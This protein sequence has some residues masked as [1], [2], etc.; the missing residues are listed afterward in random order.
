VGTKIDFAVDPNGADGC[1]ATRFTATI[2]PAP[3]SAMVVAD[4]AAEFS[5]TQGQDNWH[6]G[7]Y[8]KSADGNGVY[9]FATDFNTIDP[10]WTFGGA[11]S[12]GPGDPPWTTL[13]QIDIHPNGINNGPEQ[14]VIRRWVSEVT[15]AITID[16]HFAKSNPGGSGSSFHVF[17]NGVLR[18][19]VSLGGTDRTG[20]QRVLNLNVQTGDKIDFAQSP[21]GPSGETDDGADGSVFNAVIY[22]HAYNPN[23]DC[24]LVADSQADWSM[25]G[26]Q[27][28]LGWRYG[29]YDRTADA[30]PGYQP[31]DFT[32]FPS[33]FP[34]ALV[35]PGAT[36]FWTGN[37]W[38]WQPPPAPWDT[39]GRTDVHPTGPAPEHWVM[40]RWVSTV[41]GTVR[42]DWFTRKTNPFGSGVTGK[43][44]HNGIEKDSVTLAGGDTTGVS[45]MLTLSGVNVGD[46][47]ELA[48]TPLGVGGD[49]ADGADGSANGMT[50]YS[51]VAAGDCVITDVAS[52]MKNVNS[53]AY[54]RLPFNAP[55]PACIDQLKFRLKYDDGFVAYLNG[56]E[57]ARR[58]APSLQTAGHFADSVADWS[59]SG[60]QG[61]NNWFYGYYNQTADGDG[62]YNATTDFNPTDPN[63]TF[64]GAWTLGPGD[65]PW[66][67]IGQYD[68]HPN[69]INNGHN[70]WVIRRWVSQLAGTA[71]VTLRFAKAS[72]ACGNG[73]TGRLH[74]NGSLIY[75]NT[76]A[77]DDSVGVNVQLPVTVAVGDKLDFSLDALGT[78]GDTNDGCDGSTA[79]MHVRR[80][81]LPALAWNSRATAA[82]TATQALVTEVIDISA[83]R[84]ALRQGGN[85]LAIHGLNRAI[86]DPDFL[87]APELTA[88]VLPPTILVQPGSRTNIL[89]DTA[90]FAV[91]VLTCAPASYQWHSNGV[92]MPGETASTLLVPALIENQAGY[93][94]T[95]STVAGSVTS[96][97]ATLTVNRRPVAGDNGASTAM[98]T[99]ITLS[100][101]KLLNN[102]YDP[103]GDPISITSFASPT[104]NGGSVVRVGNSITYAP[105]AGFTGNDTFTYLL[106]DNRGGSNTA[107]VAV[108][109]YSGALPS[110]NRVLLTPV[111]GGLKVRF[112]GIPG[113]TYLV[114]RATTL[115]PEAVWT[116][117]QTLNAPTHGIMEYVD[118]ANLPSAFYRTISGP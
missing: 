14:W 77:F 98:N 87:L 42:V 69:G 3:A 11:W 108:F 46:V 102:D 26:E 45:R 39:I 105:P 22:K 4:S 55:D 7:F 67:T 31:A 110:Q 48:L 51:C 44:L 86:D 24:T 16:W 25:D 88:N 19:T 97:V 104:A 38:R 56:V 34:R 9:D 93:R 64:G 43:L 106:R 60:T 91:S 41:R 75:S 73:V 116:T 30:S 47:I 111:A 33:V 90:T 62:I 52:Q 115:G 35:N 2:Q 109:V 61:A 21:I 99:P 114:Q 66:D 29:Y 84:S 40:R 89:N 13:G 94:V 68:W 20:V 78:D 70:D 50:I 8:D 85:L 57:V 100:L 92:L 96:L 27:G 54:L 76:I 18:D 49:N 36:D 118:T 103:D 107:T 53:S 113:G 15:G 83:F 65:P 72:T 5:G 80:D 10:N 81:P 1:D 28:H 23:A 79:Y 117:L 95:V 37:E 101:G 74:R 58:N 17:Q 63:W 71:T 32:Q 82:R 112:A 6:Y 59:A 12:L